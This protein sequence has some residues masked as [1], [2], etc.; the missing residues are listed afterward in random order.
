MIEVGLY[1]LLRT[2]LLFLPTYP[3]IATTLLVL[4]LFSMLLG[5][6]LAMV[7]SDIKRLLAYSSVSQIGYIAMGLGVGTYLGYYGA[8]Y[9]LINH[10]L[11]K[12]LLFMCAGAII[13]SL[14]LRNIEELGG[15]GKHMPVTMACFFIGAFSLSGIPP[16]AGFLSKLTL[17]IATVQAHLWWLLIL[18]LFTSLLTLFYAVRAAYTVFWGEEKSEVIKEAKEAPL[19]ILFPIIVFAILTFI[20]GVYPQLLYPLL[21]SASLLAPFK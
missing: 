14:A 3:V 7:Q 5:A 11:A 20:L 9:H 18:T 12:S 13:Y 2:L 21:N 4:A 17:I 19:S 6:L 10:I 16:L 15:V 8:F 1:A